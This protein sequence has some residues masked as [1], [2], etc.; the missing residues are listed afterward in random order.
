MNFEQAGI[1]GSYISKE[2][3]SD[4]FRLLISYQSISASEA[5][6]RLDL[7][8][9]TVQDF[10]EAMA[11]V[12]I[13]NKEEVFE[14]KRP[15]FRYTLKSKK[16]AFDLNLD[17]LVLDQQIELDL[18]T[19]ICEKKNSGMKFTTAR[20]GR[21]FSNV[22]VFTGKGRDTT[23]R[24]ISLNINQGKFLYN[25][26]FPGTDGISVN[27]IMNKAE[28]EIIHTSEVLDIVNLLIELKVILKK[29]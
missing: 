13:L 24:T 25:L 16:I 7:H 2:Y 5:A 4:I 10:L 17:D 26:P 11:S 12:N 19:K 14:K 8:V 27:E 9:R 28:V 6:S 3:A 15:Y 29:E 21:Y 18:N 23:S 22:I 20:N 1:F